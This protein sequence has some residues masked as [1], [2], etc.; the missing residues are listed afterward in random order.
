MARP[1]E[2]GPG[3]RIRIVRVPKRLRDVTIDGEDLQG[4]QK[5]WCDDDGNDNDDIQGK[6]VEGMKW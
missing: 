2:A 3:S 1:D 6:E 4:K 5:A